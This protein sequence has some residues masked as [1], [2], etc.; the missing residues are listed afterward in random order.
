MPDHQVKVTLE[1]GSQVLVTLEPELNVERPAPQPQYPS[2]SGFARNAVQSGIDVAKNTAGGVKRLLSE[3]PAE[4]I[5]AFFNGIGDRVRQYTSDIHPGDAESNA[6]INQQAAGQLEALG[7]KPLAIAAA[8]N[9]VQTAGQIL[10]V[11]LAYKDPVGVALDAATVK[12]V[13]DAGRGLASKFSKPPAPTPA[14]PA[15]NPLHARLQSMEDLITQALNPPA[16]PKSVMITPDAEPTLADMRRLNGASAASADPRFQ[17]FAKEFGLPIDENT[18]RDLTGGPSRTPLAAEGAG[19]DH[20]YMRR[21]MD[22]KGMV[23]SDLPITMLLELLGVGAGAKL[24]APL[25]KNQLL[26]RPSLPGLAT[27]TRQAGQFGAVASSPRLM[28]R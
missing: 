23:A 3:S 9:P 16:R 24:A 17:S 1:D 22:E 8:K 5:P 13:A 20:D 21:I 2:A 10:P 19:L 6:G 11:G 14:V 7:L 4:T 18:V 15:V 26:V 12:G 28:Q 25:L 27:S